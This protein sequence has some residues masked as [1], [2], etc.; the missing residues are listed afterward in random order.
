MDSTGATTGA[1]SFFDT[2]DFRWS[3]SRI[4]TPDLLMK[5]RMLSKAWLRVTDNFIDERVESGVMIVVGGNDMSVDRNGWS[6]DEANALKERRSLVAQV[7]F[8]LK[9]TK[10]GDHACLFSVN[11]VV[12]EIPEGVE[13]ISQG[14]FACCS[15]LTT[16]LSRRH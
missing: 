14:A 10:V 12:V 8:L 13:S 7:V 16:V 3:F 4:V 11:L 15:S 9:I 2:D 1:P 5:T 6:V